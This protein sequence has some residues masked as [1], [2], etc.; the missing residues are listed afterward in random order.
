MKFTLEKPGANVVKMEITIPAKDADIAYDSAVKRFS[1]YVNIPGFRKGKAPKNMIERQVGVDRIK[2]EA[3]ENLLPSAIDEIVKEKDLD[4]ITQPNIINYEF[5]KGKDLKVTVVAEERPEVVLGKYKDLSVQIQDIPVSK[6]AFDQALN[7]LLE[8]HKT[9]ESIK[10]NRKA[11]GTDVAVIDFEGSVDGEKI[12]GGKG[13]KYALDLGNSSF[14]PGF[15]EAIVGHKV[16][17]EFDINVTFPETYGNKE[18]AGKPAVFAIKLH[19]LQEKKLPE[20]TDEFVQKIGPFKTVQELKDDIQQYLETQREN[21]NKTNAESEVFKTIIANSTVDIPKT[22]IDRE[23]QSIIREYQS[24]LA[25]QGVSW[26][27]F[28]KAQDGKQIMDSIKEDARGRIKNSL[29]IDQ[30]AKEEGLKL[31]TNDFHQ[32][33]SEMSANYGVTPDIL[34]KEVGQSPNFISSLTHQAMHDKVRD[35]VMMNNKVILKEATGA[36]KTAK[37]KPATKKEAAAKKGS[38]K[39]ETAKKP[40]AKKMAKATTKK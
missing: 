5:E 30:I 6:E 40:A 26:D 10:E 38:A 19:E 17:E 11:N 9:Q 27:A 28:L 31:E 24:R 15:A 21:A 8:R 3:I 14:I 39:K 18:L 22:M 12:Q 34:M 29:V 33:L 23:M 36:K 2:A 20:L 7:G 13:E 4:L 1:L 25:Q 16:G 32:K 35:F 37:E